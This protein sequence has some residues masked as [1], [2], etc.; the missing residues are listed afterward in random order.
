[1]K[2]A[3][4]VKMTFKY[5]SVNVREHHDGG[6][7]LSDGMIVNTTHHESLCKTIP[8][9]LSA[10]IQSGICRF[11]SHSGREG[12]IIA[13]EYAELTTAQKV[14]I[15]IMLKMQDYFTVVTTHDTVSKF[16][17]IRSIK[18]ES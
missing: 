13:F 11:A 18:F 7:I 5:G 16:R 3:I 10:A 12:K 1:M 9:T 4:E 8:C 17:P 14:A 15:K 2:R 6:F